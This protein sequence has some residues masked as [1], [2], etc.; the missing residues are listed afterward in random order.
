MSTEVAA[1]NTYVGNFELALEY[2]GKSLI[3]RSSELG[4]EDKRTA[5]SHYNTGLMYRING[6][7]RDAEREFIFALKSRE[8][9][10]GKFS[11]E[12]A[13]VNLSLGFTR[14]QLGMLLEALA[15][16][17]LCYNVRQ[18]LLGEAHDATAEVLALI[19]TIRGALDMEAVAE[20]EARR[21]KQEEEAR[22]RLESGGT[23]YDEKEVQK[24]IDFMNKKEMAR[25]SK[26]KGLISSALRGEILAAVA[27]SPMS[28]VEL[29]NQFGDH[30]AGWLLFR[31]LLH[32]GNAPISGKVSLSI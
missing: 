14:Q 8:V 1:F 19:D 20:E 3:I 6:Y 5:S 28:E 29:E 4:F 17:E 16:Y 27:F 18:E 10:F 12:V 24:G 23:Q 9:S 11:L 7:L 31:S 22:L 21:T 26:V 2:C 30:G 25:I 15:D 32:K 13:E